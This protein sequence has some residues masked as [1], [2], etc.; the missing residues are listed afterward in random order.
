SADAERYR[1][2]ADMLTARLK[3]LETMAAP[4]A[5]VVMG[6][7]KSSETGK[8]FDRNYVQNKPVCT[9]ADPGKLIVKF[10]VS[11]VDY[12]LMKDDLPPG[13]VLPVSIYV[14]GRT[15]HIF[16]GAVRRLPESDAKQV[17]FA[18]TQRGGGPLAVRQSGEG[19]QEVTPLAQT[20]IVEIEVLDP[21]STVKPGALVAT[22]IHCQWRS[23]AWWVGRKISEAL[24]IGLY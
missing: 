13:G 19:G 3:A 12:K 11:A 9:I 14:N 16:S 23:A 8:L 18:L 22:K 17:P 4:R 7:P 24:D 2:E 5:G 15:D 6:L 1:E 21:D 20:Y 10:P